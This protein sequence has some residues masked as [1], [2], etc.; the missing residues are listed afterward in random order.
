MKQCCYLFAAK[1]V[2]EQHFGG[3]LKKK[4]D[5]EEGS[6][7]WKERMEELISQSKKAKV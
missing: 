2:S 7:T 4:T 3:F 6:K 1:L 5:T